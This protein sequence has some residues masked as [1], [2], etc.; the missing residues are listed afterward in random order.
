MKQAGS[1]IGDETSGIGGRMEGDLEFP[2]ESELKTGCAVF[3][4]LDSA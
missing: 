4:A 1:R 3:S 2:M